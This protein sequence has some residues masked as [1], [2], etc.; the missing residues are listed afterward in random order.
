MDPRFS[1]GHGPQKHHT[2]TAQPDNGLSVSATAGGWTR[3]AD[4]ALEGLQA[5]LARFL[6]RRAQSAVSITALRRLPGGTM[7][8]AWAVDVE[9]ASGPLAGPHRLIYMPDRGGTPLGARLAREDEFRVLSVM[10][11]A[12]VR[13]PRPYWQVPREDPAA[14]AP[15]LIVERVDG[16]ALARRLFADPAFDTARARLLSQM[17]GELAR[18]HAV[19]VEELPCLAPPP[20]GKPPAEVQLDALE[21]ELT[22]IGEPHPALELGLRWLRSRAP[23]C[24][25]LVVVHGDYRLGNLMVDPGQGLRAVLDWDLSHLGDPG[26]DLGWVVIRFW[27]CVDRPRVRALGP[28]ERFF[29]GYAAVSGRRLGPDEALYWEVFA[30]LRWAIITLRQ[31]HRHLS[32]HE[33]S[34][35]LAAIGR[36]CA[37]VE[38]ELLRLLRQR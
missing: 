38:W 32:G 6:E 35:E 15:G 13:V 30:N 20:A 31:A 10:W 27:R 4:A 2:G 25:R 36:H 28:R 23:T 3:P 8:D 22:A 7:R 37:E 33:R 34:L 21:S 5:G 24:D 18:I 12:G 1:L 16:E 9:V 14:I 19:P 11:N 29:D 17:G 26:E